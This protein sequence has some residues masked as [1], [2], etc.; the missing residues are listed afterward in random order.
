MIGRLGSL[1]EVV[2]LDLEIFE[3]FLFAF[4]ERPLS[5]AILGLAFLHRQSDVPSTTKLLDA[6]RGRL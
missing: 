2:D 6:Y 3:M 1:L 4:S 5:G